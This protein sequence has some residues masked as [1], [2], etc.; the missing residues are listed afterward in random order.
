[1]SKKSPKKKAPPR[2]QDNL[3]H[4]AEPLRALAVPVSDLT[5][6]PK[7]ARKHGE[8]NLRALETSLN[9]FGFL[10]PIVVQRE[11]MVVRAGNGRLEVAKRLGW[12]HIP[13]VVVD[14]N[15]VEAA[16]FAL[17]DNRTAELA[18]WDEANLSDVLAS[19]GSLDDTLL[20]ATGFDSAALDDLLTVP[21]VPAEDS[22]P[23]PT[24][25]ANDARDDEIPD[26][27][28]EP[29]TQKGE[30]INLG[31]HELRCGDCME[32]L[33][34]L[35][36]NSVD[37][38]V[39]DPPYGLSPD[40][41][42]RTWDDIEAL[43]AEGK[44]PTGGFM[45]NAWDAGVPGVTWAKELYRVLK[46]GGHVIA[47]A[48]TRTVHRLA[49]AIEDAGLEIRDTIHWQYYSGFPKSLDVAKAIDKQEGHW[50]GRAGEV[51]IES[52]PSKGKEYERTDKGEPITESVQKWEGWGTALKPCIEPAVLARKPLEG[53]VVENIE[54]WGTGALN[55]D[56]TRLP[57]GDPAWPGPNDDVTAVTRPA[58][59]YNASS[60]MV[61]GLPDGQKSTPHPGGRWP[62]N[63]YVCSKPGRGER[64]A[65]MDDA[66]TRSSAKAA[67]PGGWKEKELKNFHPTVK[68]VRLMRWLLQLVT[69]PGGTVVE[70][71]GGSGTTLVAACDVDCKVI[72]SELDP[73][74]C[75]IIRARVSGKLKG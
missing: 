49:S 12:K 20:G 37:A 4:I 66:P 47:F 72:S 13:A 62:G 11:G 34:S 61:P 65:G 45:G 15:D 24:P 33:R 50:R 40:G 10:E 3:D 23:V 74:Y 59:G 42:A 43:R 64:D 44:G 39:T 6:D 69:P 41:R 48:S 8:A 29:V 25:K 53:T 19:I 16:A 21:D 55:I 68:P 28:P 14:Q 73:A 1:M 75:D 70:P 52:Q 67:G 5:P 22:S 56:A 31:P 35:P 26:P 32:M 9:R 36:D 2:P 7:N 60:Y 57:P 54:K 51:T 30:V 18:E 58:G 63:V 17:A 27:P 46:P 38:V 71:F